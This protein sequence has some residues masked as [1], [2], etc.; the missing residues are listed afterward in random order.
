MPCRDRDEFL[1]GGGEVDDE[2]SIIDK[3]EAIEYGEW[4]TRR[5][6]SIQ[7]GDSSSLTPGQ[8]MDRQ[9]Q[10]FIWLNLY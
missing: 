6:V 5:A 3:E 1:G 2:E 10:V 9:V 8:I 4:R 7:Y